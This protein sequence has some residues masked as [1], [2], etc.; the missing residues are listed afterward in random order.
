[1]RGSWEYEVAE[2]AGLPVDVVDSTGAGDSFDAG[3]LYG[4]IEGW[5]LR[6]TLDLAVACGSLSVAGIGGT[7]TQPTLDAARAALAAAGR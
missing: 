1:M 4:F 3:F 5:P 7:A 2:A 6:A